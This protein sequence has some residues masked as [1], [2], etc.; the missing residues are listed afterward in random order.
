[1]GRDRALSFLVAVTVKMLDELGTKPYALICGL[2]GLMVLA[3]L[4]WL[5][6]TVVGLMPRF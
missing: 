6:D 4:F 5:L 2:V 3:R 1:M